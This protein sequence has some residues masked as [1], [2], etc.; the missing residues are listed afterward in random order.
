MQ[1][2]THQQITK[3]ELEDKKAART[4]ELQELHQQHQHLVQAFEQQRTKNQMRASQLEGMI[5]E[6]QSQIDEKFPTKPTKPGKAK[7]G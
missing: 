6:L 4:A 1:K 3:K 7:P 5:L 2:P